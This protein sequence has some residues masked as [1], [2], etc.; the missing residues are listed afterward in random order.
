MKAWNKT[1]QYIKSKF[2]PQKQSFNSETNEGSKKD[3]N[4]DN[5]NNV[6]NERVY[7]K[8][9]DLLPKKM[10]IDNLEVKPRRYTLENNLVI[11][12]FVPQIK[13]IKIYMIPSKFLLNKKGFKDLKRNQNN[14]ILLNSKKY[15]ISCPNLEDEESDK[16]IYKFY[17]K[18]S[19]SISKEI[20]FEDKKDN[21]NFTRKILQNI[22]KRGIPKIA[23]KN[24]EVSKNKYKEELNLGY[25]SGDDLYDFDELNNY[26]LAANNEENKPKKN[27]NG[28]KEKNKGRE[29]FNSWSI[30]DV[31]QKKYKL[32]DE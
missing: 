22:K 20:Y 3:M 25:S 16:E 1:E 10:I 32:D 27:N 4:L 17:K 14:K 11:K 9:I 8:S 6:P 12:D 19:G 21:I 30:L 7:K 2:Q 5:P 29:R 26:S 18:H 24:N 15:F 31:L 23:S 13:P 28:E